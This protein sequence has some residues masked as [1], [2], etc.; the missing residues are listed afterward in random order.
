MYRVSVV[1]LRHWEYQDNR[2]S[3]R[4]DR[5]SRFL[6]RSLEQE[7]CVGHMLPVVKQHLPQA[8]HSVADELR[9]SRRRVCNSTR[10]RTVGRPLSCPRTLLDVR[11]AGPRSTRVAFIGFAV[12]LPSC[13]HRPDE[14]GLEHC[15]DELV[16]RRQVADE[17]ENPEDC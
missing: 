7:S 3:S 17:P 2:T 12:L 8:L 11:R 1:G 5:S 16:V 13:A 4:S 14:Q 10:V 9:S 15:G 6:G